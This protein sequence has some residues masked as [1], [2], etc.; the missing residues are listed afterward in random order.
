M[1]VSGQE[2]A[3]LLPDVIIDVA[4]ESIVRTDDG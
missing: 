2:E 4:Q 3:A 1:N